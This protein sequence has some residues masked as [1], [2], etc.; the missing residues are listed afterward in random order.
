M[1]KKYH[2]T[3]YVRGRG[4]VYEGWYHSRRNAVFDLKRE[5]RETVLYS[6]GEDAGA[7]FTLFLG[8]LIIAGGRIPAGRRLRGHYAGSACSGLVSLSG[9]RIC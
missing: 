5:A 8:S 9:T 1:Y 3:V 2:G 7:D 6:F 4:T